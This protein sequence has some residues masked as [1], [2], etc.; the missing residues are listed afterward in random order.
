M[1]KIKFYQNKKLL[2]II[3]VVLMLLLVLGMGAFTYSKYVTSETVDNQ[4]AT[5]AKWG[6]VINVDTTNLFGTE[7]KI[8]NNTT[9][10]IV[11]DIGDVVVKADNNASK[12]VAPGTSGYMKITITGSAEVL[13]KLSF[14]AE[15]DSEISLGYY[16]P[17]KW[18]A[19]KNNTGSEIYSGTSFS[20]LIKNINKDGNE[21]Q[22]DGIKL[23]IN[24]SV[25]T[26]YTISWKWSFEESD[27]ENK[28][29]KDTAIGYKANEKKFED[30]KDNISGVNKTDYNGI[31]TKLSFSLTVSIEQIQ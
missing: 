7:Y 21:S 25:K 19:T 13:A 30:I 31:S 27:I 6:Y 1:T 18:T 14:K 16:K 26:T 23:G 22:T 29:V 9:T 17:I 8:D 20:E 3:S 28:N 12:V 24:E 4:T 10:A 5:A 15:S 2:A 11:N